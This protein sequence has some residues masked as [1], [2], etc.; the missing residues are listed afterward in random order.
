M[1]SELPST[2]QPRPHTPACLPQPPAPA[3][4][5]PAQRARLLGLRVCGRYY[6]LGVTPPGP[7]R[8]DRAPDPPRAL[9]LIRP[10]HLGDMLFLTPALAAL[11]SALPQARITLLAGPWGAEVVRTNPDLDEVVTCD[12]PGFERRPKTSVW[13]PYRLLW[14]RNERNLARW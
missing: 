2:E 7:K 13:A 6:A 4:R 8:G 5:T 1:T 14:Q 3:V 11:R 12:F 10:D 9:L